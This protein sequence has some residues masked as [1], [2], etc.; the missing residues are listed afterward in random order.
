[1]SAS[2]LKTPPILVLEQ[3]GGFAAQFR[4]RL[5]TVQIIETRIWTH[6]LEDIGSH[7]NAISIIE[8][9]SD[10]IQETANRLAYIQLRYYRSITI[11]GGDRTLTSLE[12][13]FLELGACFVIDSPR[14]LIASC[15]IIQ[16]H[17]QH[18][19]TSYA[20]IEEKVEHQMPWRPHRRV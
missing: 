12:W 4:Q 20:S 2:N 5:P 6:H 8:C 16:N 18:A 11:I 10:G 3:S 15:R 1:M 17:L 7:P 19:A 13:L 9:L 14:K